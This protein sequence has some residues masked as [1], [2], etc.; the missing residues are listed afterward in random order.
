VAAEGRTDVPAPTETE[1]KQN[2]GWYVYGILPGDVEL[3]EDIRGVGGR[4]VKLVHG[5]DLAALVSEVE[6]TG[7]LGTPEDLQA[8]QELL[9]STATGAPVLPLRFGAVMTSE[10]AVTSEL[11]EANHDD[12][13]AALE[14]LE[15][16][17]EYQ[18]KG[19][20][21]EEAILE[22]ILAEDEE[23]AQLRDELRDADPDA[24]RDARMRLGEIINDAITAKREED[25]EQLADAME[26]HCVASVVRDP[27]HELD[28]VNLAFLV[29]EDQE[30]D[31][32]EVVDDLGKQWEGRV[33]LRVLGPMAPYDFVGVGQPTEEQ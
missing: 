17:V 21:V 1:T 27:T 13:M 9:D 3:T 30:D 32:D 33:E 24:T 7:P 10:E 25:T 11:L 6:L 8:H 31:L 18:V 4:E 20:Y 14:E 15:G 22:E 16:R 2:T 29:E 26:G 12:F 28:A 19:R 23:A 5:G